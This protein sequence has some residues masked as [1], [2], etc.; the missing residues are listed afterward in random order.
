MVLNGLLEPYTFTHAS[1]WDDGGDRLP[2]IRASVHLVLGEEDQNWH[3][4]EL[5]RDKKHAEEGEKD[6]I[7][8][9]L[10]RG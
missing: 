6:D 5:K 7:D 4:K 8:R 3:K 9:E 10:T 1:T 2:F